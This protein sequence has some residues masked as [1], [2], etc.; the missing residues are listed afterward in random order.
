MIRAAHGLACGAALAVLLAACG[1]DAPEPEAVETEIPEELAGATMPQVEVDEQI[2]T[3]LEERVATLGLMNKRNNSSREIEIRPGES[4][5]D[6]DVIVRLASC[7]KTA[8]WEDP[9]QTGAF[10]QV[11][12]RERLEAGDDP[13]WRGVFSGW[14]FKESPSINVVE[15]P[16]YDVWV[17]DCAM[18]FPG[19]EESAPAPAED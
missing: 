5:R 9:P 10:V 16:I 15:H 19:E 18:S 13:A 1:R 11:F 3:P 4:K 2:G 12:V 17:K 14:L 6:G 7:E 8:P